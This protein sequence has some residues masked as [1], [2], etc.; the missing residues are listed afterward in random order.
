MRKYFLI[1]SRKNQVL[2]GFKADGMTIEAFV[3]RIQFSLEYAL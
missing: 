1:P 2:R 3:T